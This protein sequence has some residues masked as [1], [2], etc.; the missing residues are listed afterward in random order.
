MPI[1]EILYLHHSHY[2][3][4]FVHPAP[5]QREL[6]IRFWRQAL[7]LVERTP[8]LCWASELT[9]PVID[10]LEDAGPAEIALARRLIA[11]GRVGCGALAWNTTPLSDAEDFRRLTAGATTLRQRLDDPCRV[12][13]Q[14]DVNG[15]PW[16]A[17]GMLR[18]AGVDLLSMAI[19]VHQG[20]CAVGRHRIFRWRGPDGR[21][22][23]V[24]N[25]DHYDQFARMIRIEHGTVA[26]AQAGWREYLDRLAGWGVDLPFIYLTCTIPGF[27]DC[28]PPNEEIAGLIAAW[29]RERAGP[30]IRCVTP[31]GLRAAVM[32]LPDQA[33]PELA[34]DWTDW[35]NFGAGSSAAHTALARRARRCVRSA[36][37]IAPQAVD[38]RI[39]DQ[40]LDGIA[41]YN[42][43]TWGSMASCSRPDAE[44]AVVQWDAKAEMASA[45]AARAD[46]CLRDALHA[47]S[48]NAD[49]G[50]G[51]QGVVV[52]NPGDHPR[53]APLVIP[54][55]WRKPDWL[56]H[57]GSSRH[58]D[59]G[60]GFTDETALQRTPAI[61]IPARSWR[62][63]TWAELDALSAAEPVVGDGVIAAGGLTL[64][65]EPRTGRVLNL[66]TADG[67]DV[68]ASRPGVEACGLVHE[69]VDAAACPT[70]LRDAYFT[71]DWAQ[72]HRAIAPWKPDWPVRRLGPERVEGVAVERTP[73]AATLVRRLR[74]RGW[75]RLELRLTLR[76]D[77][78]GLDLTLDG[79]IDDGRDPCATYLL[80]PLTLPAGWRCHFDTAGATTELD[81][82]QLPGAC[83]DWV[84][85]DRWIC[86][87]Q[88]DRGATLLCPDAPLVMPGGFGF[89]LN[90]GAIPRPADPLLL[91]WPLNTYWQTNFRAAQ[92]GPLNLRWRL[93]THGAFATAD[94]AAR[95]EDD[96][97]PVHP[98]LTILEV[99]SGQM[100]GSIT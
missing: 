58:I 37:A 10:W 78:P 13:F 25:G 39:A 31:E 52:A 19:N 38:R 88:A 33:L 62:M 94:A 90:R 1:S 57:L 18:D 60:L 65:F 76:S 4:G 47:V 6:Q 56:Y 5:V 71:T 22:I 81:A 36:Q 66:G 53:C 40:A 30:P 20:G 21:S 85:V 82:E 32:A 61:T 69:S 67:W 83:R 14:H 100:A 17:I 98:V 96:H 46:L 9:R 84:T 75:R 92:P 44:D 29:N 93:L 43:H 51:P 11:S 87:H 3:N 64:R 48:G 99:R 42:E 80:L 15:I 34:G 59:A 8:E 12:A 70:A 73:G 16:A 27:D 26:A 79:Q 74:L 45:A 97:L 91:A 77:R 50:R 7:A 86:L 28:N 68:L 95:A 24:Y 72:I 54:R 23:R 49:W 63:L 2:D 41:A 35:W 55:S 89:G